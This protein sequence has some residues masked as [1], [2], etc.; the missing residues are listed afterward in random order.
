MLQGWAAQGSLGACLPAN[1][2][3]LP[4]LCQACCPLLWSDRLA[5]LLPLLAPC[6]AAPL[7]DGVQAGQSAPLVCT[8]GAAA[9]SARVRQALCA[10]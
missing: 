2:Q 3:D 7:K 10:L 9:S 4:I 6:L 8:A 1:C 5:H